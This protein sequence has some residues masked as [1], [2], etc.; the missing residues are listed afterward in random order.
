MV[1]IKSSLI[2]VIPYNVIWFA[3]KPNFWNCLCNSYKQSS[4]SGYI[5]GYLKESFYTKIIDLTTSKET[6]E[7]GFDQNTTY[8][9]RRAIKDGVITVMETGLRRFI[10]FY[11]S[12]AETKHLKK[13]TK[14]FYKYQSALVITKAM[15]NG[16]DV[17][18]H[19]YL[20]DNTLKRIR[21]LHSASLFRNES[22]KQ[23]RAVIGRANRLLHFKDMCFFK[24]QGFE[25]YDLGGYA[26]QTS[27]ESLARIN[28][29]KDSFGGTLVCENDYLP[30]L[31]VVH[32][33]L[34]KI[35]RI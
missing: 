16:Q 27:D 10:E 24:Q 13:L 31:V 11:N 12:F 21:L 17:V 5:P 20:R 6:F 9:I 33:F 34:R 23:S 1:Q 28:Q 26:Y 2:K 18:M 15:Y 19:A 32:S 35:A 30:I 14:E 4:Y 8:E 7:A 22:D 3:Q 29:F 25:T